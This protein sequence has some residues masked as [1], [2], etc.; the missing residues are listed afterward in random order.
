MNNDHEPLGHLWVTNFLRRNLRVHSVVGRLIE[1]SRAEAATL[2]LIRDF[3]E[4]FER[5]RLRLNIPPKA[6]W[7]M[8]ETGL[9]LGVCNNSQVIALS[10]KKKA[11]KKTPENR[12]WVSIVECVSATGQRLCPAIIFKGKH[13]QT[14][15]FPLELILDWFYT[16][17]E[18]G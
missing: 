7:N 15:W 4:L 6:I 11:Y 5:T 2:E 10:H 9:A 12:E 16:L 1:A 3:L 17:L 8:D 14:T 13:L 18:N